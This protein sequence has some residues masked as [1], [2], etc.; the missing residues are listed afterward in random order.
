VV[1]NNNPRALT[2]Q[3]GLG[4]D[5]KVKRNPAGLVYMDARPG[6]P[7]GDFPIQGGIKL[8]NMNEMIDLYQLNRRSYNEAQDGNSR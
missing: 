5:E 3:E 8:R 2:D 7:E 4:L 1:T 6:D